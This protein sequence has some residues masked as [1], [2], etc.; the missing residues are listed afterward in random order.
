MTG[1]KIQA[2]PASTHQCDVHEDNKNGEESLAEESHCARGRYG[3]EGRAVSA[4]AA[5]GGRALRSKL[6]RHW[7]ERVRTFGVEEV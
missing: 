4:P 7:R 2:S 1:K 5:A 3:S 6:L